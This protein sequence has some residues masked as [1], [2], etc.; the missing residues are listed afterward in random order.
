MIPCP[1]SIDLSTQT[2]TNLISLVMISVTTVYVI[3]TSRIARA[4]E[5]QSEAAWRPYVV[6]TT[7][8]G[9]SGMLGLYVR[10]MGRSNANNLLLSISDSFHQSGTPGT[11]YEMSTHHAFTN[12]IETFPPP[13]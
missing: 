12:G 7:K 10:N 2:V 1:I 6:I 4:A 11:D 3:L 9:R 13:E 5:E 8:M